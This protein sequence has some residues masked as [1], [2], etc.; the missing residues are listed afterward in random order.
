MMNS[1]SPAYVVSAVR[2]RADGTSEPSDEA[3]LAAM[4]LG[5]RAAASAFV[6]RFQARAYGLALSIIGDPGLAEDAAQEALTRAWRNAAAYDPRR[7]SVATWLLTI[8]RNLA[9]D[10][11]RMHRATPMDPGTMA[12]WEVVSEEPGPAQAAERTETIRDV[13]GAVR[14]LPVDQRRALVLAAFYGRTAQEIATMEGV[15]LGTAKTRIRAGMR[16]LRAML[17]EGSVA[18]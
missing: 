13:Q 6:H 15:P 17:A 2:E 1:A 12:G 9:I 16:K 10:T 3:L 11:L 18:P 8:T 14:L 4:G 7:G 5:E